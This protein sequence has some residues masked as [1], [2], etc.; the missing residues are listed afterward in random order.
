MDDPSSAQAALNSDQQA[1]MNQ[2]KKAANNETIRQSDS[3][4]MPA[5]LNP[6]LHSTKNYQRKRKQNHA[7]GK[8]KTI[9]NV[10]NIW[11]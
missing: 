6:E 1:N 7:I 8:L 10:P 2:T 11:Q 4:I 5:P 3:T 9:V